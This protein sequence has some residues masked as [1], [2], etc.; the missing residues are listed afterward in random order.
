MRS[1]LCGWRIV[2][3]DLVVVAFA[4][5]KTAV[6]ASVAGIISR[7]P[8]TAPASPSLAIVQLFVTH[9]GTCLRWDTTIP[10]FATYVKASSPLAVKHNTFPLEDRLVG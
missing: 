5:P 1:S 4:A 9:Y 8:S 7:Q 2:L 6:C 10:H 3:T